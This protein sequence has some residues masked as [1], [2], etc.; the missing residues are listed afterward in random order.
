MEIPVVLAVLWAFVGLA[1]P[2][3][4]VNS[5]RPEVGVLEIIACAAAPLVDPQKYLRPER[6]GFARL[7]TISIAILAATTIV[8]F[9]RDFF[10]QHP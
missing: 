1:V 9:A 4:Y 6:R 10:V 8:F 3:F 5:R 2:I 7:I